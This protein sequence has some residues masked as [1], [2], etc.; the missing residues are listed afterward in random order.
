MVFVAAAGGGIK[1][2]AFTAS[3][4]DC[5]FQDHDNPNE[6]HPC[7][8]TDAYNRLFA[9]S[10]ASGGSVGIASV[11]AERADGQVGDDWVQDRLGNDLLSP[12]LAWQVM[13][14]VPNAIARF[15]PGQDR[16]QV[17]SRLLERRV[18]RRRARSWRRA[19]LRRPDR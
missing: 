13:V 7:N 5:L 10:G 4:I 12:E 18:R 15:Q 19:L 6:G 17:L 3:T 9:A 11:V 8:D 16:G 14:E 1:A 2:A